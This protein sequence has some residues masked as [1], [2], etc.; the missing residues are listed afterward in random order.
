M[1]V[2]SH[3]QAEV[4]KE[5]LEGHRSIPRGQKGSVALGYYLTLKRKHSGAGVI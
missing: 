2:R 3:E 5:N 1:T 4:R